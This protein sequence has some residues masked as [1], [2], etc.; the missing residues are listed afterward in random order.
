MGEDKEEILEVLYAELS[1]QK[2]IFQANMGRAINP[3]GSDEYDTAKT[4]F[5][6]ADRRIKEIEKE[7]AHIKEE[8]E[9]DYKAILRKL[10]IV[11]DKLIKDD[12]WKDKRSA[13]MGVRG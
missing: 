3:D 2:A 6:G 5:D 1:K 4:A 13:D 12:D 8:M 11:W 9:P 7:I 10:G